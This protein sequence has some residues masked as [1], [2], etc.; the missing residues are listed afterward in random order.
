MDT[1][2][3]KIYEELWEALVK[4]ANEAEE[5]FVLNPQGSGTNRAIG[6][7][8]LNSGSH[9]EM[10]FTLSQNKRKVSASW[11][12]VSVLFEIDICNDGIVCL[13]QKGNPVPIEAAAH[14]IM[15]PFLFP[16]LSN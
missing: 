10:D 4:I 3:P 1:H 5:G 7:G 8:A 14:Q 2:A 16:E 15:G 6:C 11:A 13:K 9:R 12:G